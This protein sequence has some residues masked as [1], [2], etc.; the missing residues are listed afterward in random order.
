MIEGGT[1]SAKQHATFFI[2]QALI[3]PAIAM[4][5]AM[6]CYFPIPFMVLCLDAVYVIHFVGCY[7][8]IVEE[9][10]IRGIQTHKSQLVRLVGLTSA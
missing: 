2:C 7:C 9:E 10:A 1:I 4:V 3:Y 8:V 6:N 5:V